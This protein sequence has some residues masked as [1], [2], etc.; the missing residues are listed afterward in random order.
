MN[1]CVSSELWAV[2]TSVIVQVPSDKPWIPGL[3]LDQCVTSLIGSEAM[4][5]QMTEKGGTTCFISNRK[6]AWAV[7]QEI[8]WWLVG[9]ETSSVSCS[10]SNRPAS[11]THSVSHAHACYLCTLASVLQLQTDDSLPVITLSCRQ[12]F[13][14]VKKL[15]WPQCCRRKKT[16]DTLCFVLNQFF[17]IIFT[18]ALT[19]ADFQTALPKGVKCNPFNSKP[20]RIL[21]INLCTKSPVCSDME[22]D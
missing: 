16:N 15:L 9:L 8:R 13:S 10:V 5:Q 22:D 12:Q 18:K 4:K 11:V 3:V 2:S 21:F 6:Q 14:K 7:S 20:S 19:P 17:C 1:S